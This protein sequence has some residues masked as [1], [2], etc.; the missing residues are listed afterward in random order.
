MLNQESASAKQIVSGSKAGKVSLVDRQHLSPQDHLRNAAHGL[1]CG[2][3]PRNPSRQ[4]EEE[5]GKAFIDAAVD[6]QVPHVVYSSVDRGG[7]E[8]SWTRSTKVPHFTS[9]H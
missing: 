6:H 2:G 5:N 9:K 8:R 1:H 7:D 4:D 3:D